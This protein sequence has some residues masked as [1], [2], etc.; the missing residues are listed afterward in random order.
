MQSTRAIVS[1]DTLPNGGW[2]MEDINLRELEEGE[3]LVEMVASGVCHTDI[4]IG[5]IPGGAAPIANY[6][7]VLGHEGE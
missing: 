2:K 6:P 5:S 4:L 7:R 3:L 1:H